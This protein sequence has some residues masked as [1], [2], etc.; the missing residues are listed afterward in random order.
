[1][2]KLT[3][4]LSFLLLVLVAGCSLVPTPTEMPTSLPSATQA[5]TAT[6]TLAAPTATL[7]QKTP[8][9]T[10][11]IFFKRTPAAMPTI[12]PTIMAM[13]KP[14]ISLSSLSPDGEWR[15]DLIAYDCMQ[16]GDG[17]EVA[18]DQL[19]MVH[20]TDMSAVVVDFQVQS[21]EGTGARG[22]GPLFWSS[23]S[24]FFYYTTARMGRPDGCGYWQ[25]PMYRIDVN[26]QT[27]Q[28]IGVG[29]LSPD[30]NK[31]AAWD[32]DNQWIWDVN[33]Q[34]ITGRLFQD[35]EIEEGPIAWGPDS[36]QLVFLQFESSCPL[37]GKSYVGYT[38]LS[39]NEYGTYFK[40]D[41]HTFGDVY[42]YG[43]D[44]Y[45]LVDADG[46]EYIFDL[47]KWQLEPFE[48]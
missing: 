36:Q 9:Q 35:T 46:K 25:P 5:P 3:V 29:E 12:V 8:T 43:F 14:Q 11:T 18:Y 32:Q 42:W 2:K 16:V 28:Y 33:G 31:I 30:H 27:K 7:A 15:A 22:I 26:F 21:C 10:P 48:D 39:E 45:I 24:R 34:K 37:S 1:M 19:N 4:C 20:L 13:A 38:N 44:K 6:A 40:Y 47:D 23:N 41:D 17:D